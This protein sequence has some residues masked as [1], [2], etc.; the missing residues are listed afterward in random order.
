[1][2][3]PLK[4]RW[5]RALLMAVACLSPTPAAAASPPP[6]A[7]PAPGAP[8]EG[9]ASD[10]GPTY[11]P[12]TDGQLLLWLEPAGAAWWAT[13]RHPL[14]DRALVTGL[15]VARAA[16]P[17]RLAWRVH[18]AHEGPLDGTVRFL[19]VD[20]LSFERV[21]RPGTALRPWWR[22]G[23]GFGLDLKG[24]QVDL[25]GDGYFNPANG[26]SG[27][28]MVGHGWG[29]DAWLGERW[30]LRIE[31]NARAHVGAGRNGLLFGGALGVGYAWDLAAL[32]PPPEQTP[33]PPPA[34]VDP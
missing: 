4:S 24:D 19:M 25:G 20:F 28:L 18:L 7:T 2:R 17:A 31:A 13:S 11:L 9:A 8:S 33:A 34:E 14:G 21:Y 30:F 26:A 29:L 16:G 5:A 1:M 6:D 10:P 12:L 23:L 22:L 27:G 15:G 32:R 3:N